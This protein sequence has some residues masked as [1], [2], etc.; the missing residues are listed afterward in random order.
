MEDK[1][2][3]VEGKTKDGSRRRFRFSLLP[4]ALCL[5]PLALI[6][7]LLFVR[8]DAPKPAPKPLSVDEADE[9]LRRAAQTALGGREGVVLVLDAQ[10]GRV[11]ASAGGRAVF[12]EATPPGSA[13]KPFTMLAALRTGVLNG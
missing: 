10:T 11:R 8:R 3:R 6:S 12:E 1:R 5:L 9:V 2:Q 4:F 7:G 13:V